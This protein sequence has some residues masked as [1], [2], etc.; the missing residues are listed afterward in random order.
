MGSYNEKN[1]LFAVNTY[2]YTLTHSAKDC[3]EQLAGKGYKEFELMTYPGH[4]W[5]A[6]MDDA[7]RADLADYIEKAGLSVCTLNMPNIDLN[8]AG[9]TDEIRAYTLSVLEGVIQLAADI[10]VPGVVLGPG[11]A[12]PLM[13]APKESLLRNLYRG[14]D[15]L[16]PLAEKLGVR[17]YFENM[18]FA[19]LP[20]AESLMQALDGYGNPDL[21]VV[22][23]VA[24]GH[25]INEDVCKALHRVKDRLA[26]V[27]LSDTNQTVYRHDAVGL[28]DVDFKPIPATLKEIGFN[29][30]PVLEVIV[31]DPDA[32]I[33]TTTEKLLAMGWGS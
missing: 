30:R 22:Y 28:G 24:N 6:D 10:K 31:P 16:A 18:P 11:K 8:I 9:A 27:H 5:H 3:L 29:G 26:V 23:D 12:N 25:F 7:A 32:D 4:L 21:G 17:L 20:D 13:A 14:L 1:A 2:S 19:F 33:E 15:R